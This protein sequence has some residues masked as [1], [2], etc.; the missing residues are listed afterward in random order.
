VLGHSLRS[1]GL[2]QEEL[3]IDGRDQSKHV[4]CSIGQSDTVKTA[5]DSPA[6]RL[7]NDFVSRTSNWLIFI[8]L[9]EIRRLELNVLDQRSDVQQQLASSRH[10]PIHFPLIEVPLPAV[11]LEGEKEKSN[12]IV[13]GNVNIFPL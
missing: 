3:G 12:A 9:S 10:T 6:I 13:I 2:E 11:C 7:R 1:I 8:V 5:Q 4:T